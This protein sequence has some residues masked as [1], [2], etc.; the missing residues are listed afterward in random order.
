MTLNRAEKIKIQEI[1]EKHG[2]T[3]EEVE[4]IIE[5]QYEFIREKIKEI[6]LDEDLTKDQ[7]LMEKTNFNIPSIAKLYASYYIYSEINKKKKK[8]GN[9]M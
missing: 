5:S 1:A 7:F 4:S 2:L 9:S 6:K 3:V 8:K